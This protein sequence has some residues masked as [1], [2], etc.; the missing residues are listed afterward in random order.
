MS[1]ISTPARIGAVA[2]A[3]REPAIKRTALCASPSHC[4]AGSAAAPTLAPAISASTARPIA[5]G[6]A[7]RRRA[8]PVIMAAR[9]KGEKLRRAIEF[10]VSA[11]ARRL[12]CGGIHEKDTYRYFLLAAIMNCGIEDA[13][14]F[15]DRNHRHDCDVCNRPPIR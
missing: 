1:L 11:C 14:L 6:A 13:Y 2:A 5:I 15:G 10:I 3:A 4:D 9:S 8:K 7:N 12:S